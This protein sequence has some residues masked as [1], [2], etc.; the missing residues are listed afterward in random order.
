MLDLDPSREAVPAKDAATLVVVRDAPQGTVEVFCVERQ[1]AGF[2]GG[3]VVFPGGKV[4]PSDLDPAWR[5]LVSPPVHPT[6]PW[7]G[8]E[9]TSWGLA[10]AACREALEEA[11]ILPL[12]GGPASHEMLVDWQHRVARKETTLR[13]L[14]AAEERAIDLAAMVPLARWITPVAESRRYDTRFFLLV[15]DASLTGR[16]DGHETTAS[17]WAAPGEV[18]R[19]FD[20]GELELAPPTH[21]TLEILSRAGSA[22]D[23]LSFARASCL[24]PIVP[25]LVRAGE[26]L[27]LA[28]PGDPEH[29]V[30]VARSPGPSRYVLSGGRFVPG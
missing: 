10:I 9:A 20:C 27:A 11:A 13:E 6:S 7:A 16:H 3:A 28:L 18:L 29:D 15:G 17:F 22:R 5:A 24:E 21:R 2:L 30:P 23:A 19:R 25:R 26:T 8:D 1:R 12:V 14:V 4:D